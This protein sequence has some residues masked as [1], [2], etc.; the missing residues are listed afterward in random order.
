MRSAPASRNSTGS[1]TRSY[2]GTTALLLADL[3]ADRGAYDEASQLVRGG[4]AN[5][6]TT[7]TSS[8][9]SGSILE[10]CLA[11]TQR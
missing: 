2:R 6:S 1:G 4:A 10:G 11:A 5:A 8:M 7:T 3:L 9:P